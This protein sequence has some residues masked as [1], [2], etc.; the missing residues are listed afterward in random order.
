M[1]KQD[2][3][4]LKQI[5]NHFAKIETLFSELSN[6]AKDETLNYHNEEFSLNYCVRW[7]NQAIKDLLEK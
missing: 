4:L 2:K 1:N 7:G 3:Q 5:E 6:S